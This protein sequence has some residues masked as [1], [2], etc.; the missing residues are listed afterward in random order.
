MH[1]TLAFGLT[2]PEIN[3][4][5]K[6]HTQLPR[7]SIRSG[8]VFARVAFHHENKFCSSSPQMEPNIIRLKCR[9]SQ[10]LA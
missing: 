1:A 8:V 2:Q 10:P 9:P 3:W 4:L 7:Q 5:K 6:K